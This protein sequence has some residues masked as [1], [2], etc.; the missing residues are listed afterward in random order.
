MPPVL[1]KSPSVD[2]RAL[3]GSAVAHAVDAAPG[4]ADGGLDVTPRDATPRDATPRDATPLGAP[5][6][7]ST[8]TDET[9][10]AS[11]ERSAAP[12]AAGHD[13]GS[14]RSGRGRRQGAR[15]GAKHAKVA[16]RGGAKAEG[17]VDGSLR[18]AAPDAQVNWGV[19]WPRMQPNPQDG[20]ATDLGDQVLPPSDALAR[21]RADVD[22]LAA[23][24][25]CPA[26]PGLPAICL[27]CDLPL[28]QGLPVTV[29]VGAEAPEPLQSEVR[30]V[31]APGTSDM[32]SRVRDAARRV[33]RDTPV[34]AWALV[35]SGEGWDPVDESALLDLEAGRLRLRQDVKRW[36][37]GDAGRIFD[38]AAWAA[39]SGL[40][41]SREVVRAARRDAGHVLGLDRSTWRAGFHRVLVAPRASAG[42]Q[43]LYDCGVLP[44][45]VHEVC[46]MV[47][48]HRSCPVHH[49]DIWDHTLQVVDKCPPV[50]AVRWTA[51]MHDTGKVW[52]RTVSPKGKVHFF[53]HEELGASLMEGVAARFGLPDALRERV[54]YVIANHAR[55][56]VYS[57][58]W[59]DSAVRRLIR[60]MGPHLDD[61]VAFSRSDY[62]TKRAWRIKEVRA[63]G[64]ELIER[65]DEV[66]ANDA[67][68]PPLPKGFGNL[69][70]DATG[71]RGGPWLGEL[72]RW[73]EAEVDATRLAG[74]LPGA[75]YLDY[76]RSHAPHLLAEA[77]GVT[78]ATPL[79]AKAASTDKG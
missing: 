43:F 24:G 27:A 67:R 35:A 55:A 72:Q 75:D 54:V 16:P 56:N 3:G 32:A 59:T 63:L 40:R 66:R 68:V 23:A 77:A 62:T 79:P 29:V 20:D 49:K 47:D 2:A 78:D 33:A 69:V 44:L 30:V 9:R 38:I 11:A 71:R 74:G 52:T 76:V 6:K 4:P 13:R 7:S 65:I 45:M 34:R 53:R 15:R 48:F 17:E 5:P 14:S 42:L 51:L 50:L 19:G 28:P 61:V 60:D 10:A 46:A 12:R 8:R 57:T 25:L 26:V 21:L 73:L 18:G 31:V 64:V 58:Q 39:E 36:L 22:A 70:M 37:R 41:P 1:P